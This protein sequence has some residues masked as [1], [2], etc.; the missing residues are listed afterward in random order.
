MPSMLPSSVALCL[1][2]CCS[3]ISR[4]TFAATLLQP[5]VAAT[6]RLLKTVG[7]RMMINPG[8]STQGPKS[9]P[10]ELLEVAP[11]VLRVD[12]SE[13]PPLAGGHHFVT[14][15]NPNLEIVTGDS[16][17]TRFSIGV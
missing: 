3:S 17:L 2:A 1:S 14:S 13:H 15:R 5:L 8:S 10:I 16:K 4:L 11:P 6:G 12:Y 7:S 9:S